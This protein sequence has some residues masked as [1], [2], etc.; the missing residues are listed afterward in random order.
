[1]GDTHLSSV[2]SDFGAKIERAFITAYGT[3]VPYLQLTWRHEYG[4]AQQHINARFAAD[5]MGETGFTTTGA[6]PAAD[7]G[8]L[9][10]GVTL[11]RANN[12]SL[13][14]RYTL[15]AAPGF[16]SHAGGVRLRLVF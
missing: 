15:Q 8:A 13:T 6:S 14:A 2:T 3:V 12:L 11:L 4:N 9:S 5:P 1:M 10:A 16:V 7:M